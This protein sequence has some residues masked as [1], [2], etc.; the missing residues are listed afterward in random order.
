MGPSAASTTN[1]QQD[2]QLDSTFNIDFPSHSV[3]PNPNNQTCVF[4]TT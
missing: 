3:A 4:H 1:L 2:F